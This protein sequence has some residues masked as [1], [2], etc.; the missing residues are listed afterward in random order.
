MSCCWESLLSL[1][2]ALLSVKPAPSSSIVRGT[3]GSFQQCSSI[4]LCV[5][6]TPFLVLI[7]LQFLRPSNDGVVLFVVLLIAIYATRVAL[8]SPL[9]ANNASCELVLPRLGS[10]VSLLSCE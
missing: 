5:H 8:S 2:S 6:T 9:Q 7:F 3:V 10:L 4:H 1:L